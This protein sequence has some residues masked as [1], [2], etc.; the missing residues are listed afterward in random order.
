MHTVIV[1]LHFSGS[2]YFRDTRNERVEHM[3]STPSIGFRGTYL[4]QRSVTQNRSDFFFLALE[5]VTVTLCHLALGRRKQ[6]DQHL[7]KVETC[8]S[9]NNMLLFSPR[10]VKTEELTEQMFL[11]HG[12]WEQGVG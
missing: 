8:L 5:Y 9:A 12:C 3:L 10:T 2:D 6:K 4:T 7:G 11:K 1:G